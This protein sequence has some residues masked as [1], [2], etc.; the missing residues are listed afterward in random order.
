MIWGLLWL[1]CTNVGKIPSKSSAWL[2]DH[3]RTSTSVE[4]QLAMIEEMK[5]VEIQTASH[6]SLK[7]VHP[8]PRFVKPVLK[9]W[10][11]MDPISWMIA[12]TSGT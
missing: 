10:L 11:L 7:S 12:E 8:M 9:L 1:A 2:E 6:C 3:L 4:G 5:F